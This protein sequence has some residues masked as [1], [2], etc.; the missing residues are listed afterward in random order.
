MAFFDPSDKTLKDT[1]ERIDG[2]VYEAKNAGRD[3]WKLAG[4]TA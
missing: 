2:A 4:V 3:N 1:L